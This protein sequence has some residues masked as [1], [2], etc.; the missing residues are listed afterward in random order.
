MLLSKCCLGVGRKEHVWAALPAHFTGIANTALL[1][2]LMGCTLKHF[3]WH[4]QAEAAQ[5]AQQSYALST[6]FHMKGAIVLFTV[7]TIRIPRNVSWFTSFYFYQLSWILMSC[8]QN[9]SG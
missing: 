1:S 6:P 5:L 3:T 8:N 4:P 7:I 2:L 9:K